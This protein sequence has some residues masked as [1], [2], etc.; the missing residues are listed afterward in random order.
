MVPTTEIL[1][2]DRI[3][4]WE[5]EPL[6]YHIPL[7]LILNRSLKATMSLAWAVGLIP[8]GRPFYKEMI[9]VSHLTYQ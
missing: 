1:A 7:V 6:L 8:L 5:T 4:P 9:T 2:V 3:G